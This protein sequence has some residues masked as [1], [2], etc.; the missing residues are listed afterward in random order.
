VT[1]L[2]A[3]LSG[4]RILASPRKCSFPQNVYTCFVADQAFSSMGGFREVK[5]PECEVDHSPPYSAEVVNE[6]SYTSTPRP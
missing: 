1:K 2:Q 4:V 3:R 6:W 5:G